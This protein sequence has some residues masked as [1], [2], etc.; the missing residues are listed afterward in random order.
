VETERGTFFIGQAAD[1]APV[2]YDS[3]DLTTHGSSSV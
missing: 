1:G 3:A 2:L